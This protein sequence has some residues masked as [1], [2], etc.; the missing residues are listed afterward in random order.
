V[1]LCYEGYFDVR[2][3]NDQWIRVAMKKGGM[4]VLPAGMYHRF[5]L[6]SN[7]Y[8]KVLPIDLHPLN[9]TSQ[10]GVQELLLV[11]SAH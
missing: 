8:I 11:A 10:V 5:T 7:N 4:I 6:D 1:F 2:D 3:Q 9:A